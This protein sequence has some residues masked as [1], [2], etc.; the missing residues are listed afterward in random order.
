LLFIVFKTKIVSQQ[1]EQKTHLVAKL[2]A[3]I[4]KN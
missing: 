4:R 3:E 1:N 2:Q